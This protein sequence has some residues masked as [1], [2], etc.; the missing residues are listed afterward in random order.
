MNNSLKMELL[1]F[2]GKKPMIQFLHKLL[3]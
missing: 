2:L 3:L 1:Q